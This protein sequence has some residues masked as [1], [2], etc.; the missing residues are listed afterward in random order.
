MLK[1]YYDSV[2]NETTIVTN[3]IKDKKRIKD[4]FPSECITFHDYVEADN[5][6]YF[7]VLSLKIKGKYVSY[8][9]PY[10]KEEIEQRKERMKY[11]R[12]Y[13]DNKGE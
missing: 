6:T 1:I 8:R 2:K 3:N 13:K 9:K 7:S 11:A 10:S 4:N 12:E 5:D